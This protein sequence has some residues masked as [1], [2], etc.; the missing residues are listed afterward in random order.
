MVM[1]SGDREVIAIVMVMVMVMAMASG[2]GDGDS[3][4]EYCHATRGLGTYAQS[5]LSIT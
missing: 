3:Y 5:S 2:D 4:P 1:T